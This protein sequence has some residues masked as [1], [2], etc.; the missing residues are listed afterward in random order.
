MA[1][2]EAHSE[3]IDITRIDDGT[4]LLQLN[5]AVIVTLANRGKAELFPSYLP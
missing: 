2:S 1:S 4:R 5:H 3:S